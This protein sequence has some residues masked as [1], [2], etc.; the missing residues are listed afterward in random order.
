MEQKD[1]YLIMIF[2]VVLITD[3][4]VG[5]IRD[6][7]IALSLSMDY[8]YIYTLIM[9]ISFLI[10]PVL[11]FIAFYLIGRKFDVRTNLR[12][13]IVI[14]LTGAYLGNF[15]SAIIYILLREYVF[16]WVSVISIFISLQFLY[17]FFTA[18]SALTIAY[19]RNND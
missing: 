5:F 4:A 6:I 9:F 7:P 15:L 17:T 11:V 13:L 2:L 19:F 14:L 18:F 12:S 8:Y 1:R 10:R 3:F 16:S